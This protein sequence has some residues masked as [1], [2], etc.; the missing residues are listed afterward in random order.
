MKKLAI[1][2]L[3]AFS[4]LIPSIGAQASSVDRLAELRIDTDTD[5]MGARLGPALYALAARADMDIIVNSKLDGTVIA[6]LTGKTVMEAYSKTLSLEMLLKT[7]YI[8]RQICGDNNT[9]LPEEEYQK[10]LKKGLANHGY[11]PAK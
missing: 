2:F 6:R 8:R 11:H 3:L 4:L 10:L 9:E 7:D 1:V 5:I